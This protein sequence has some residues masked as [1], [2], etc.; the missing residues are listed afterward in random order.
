MMDSL[1][2]FHIYNGNKLGKQITDKN[3]VTHN[4]L[5]DMIIQREA[6]RGH[7]KHQAQSERYKPTSVVIKHTADQQAT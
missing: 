4:I 3:T 6:I 7:P 2:K 1:E 5:F